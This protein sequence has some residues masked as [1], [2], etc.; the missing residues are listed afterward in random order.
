LAETVY[1][2]RTRK[3]RP[4]DENFFASLFNKENE[5]FAGFVPRTAEYWRWCCLQRPGVNQ[6]GIIVI[7]NSNQTV[8]YSVTAKS[9]EVLE[10]CVDSRFNRQ[11]ILLKLLSETLDYTKSVGSSSIVINAPSGDSDIRKVC[12]RLNLAESLPEP[13]FLSV[14]DLPELILAILKARIQKEHK[15]EVFWFHLKNCPSW[16][17]DS[18]GI[19]IIGKDV[20]IL[21]EPNAQAVTVEVEMEELASVIFGQEEVLQAILFSRIRLDHFWNLSKFIRF[22]KDLRI[23]SDWALPRADIG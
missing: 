4:G 1:D 13:M 8:G 5:R 12:E 3:Y 11:A 6:D 19:M 9:G 23:E 14:L 2:L 18:F 17:I 21:K 20:Q 15:R 16:C 10:V 7:E 22:A